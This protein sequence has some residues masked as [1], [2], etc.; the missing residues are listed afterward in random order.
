MKNKIWPVISLFLDVVLIAVFMLLVLFVVWIYRNPE[1]ELTRI[2]ETPVV[3]E[4]NIVHADEL[5]QVTQDAEGNGISYDAGAVEEVQSAEQLLHAQEDKSQKLYLRN[6]LSVPYA[7]VSKQI[8]E[9]L[10]EKVLSTGAGTVKPGQDLNKVGNFSVAAHNLRDWDAGTGF[11]HFQKFTDLVGQNMYVCDGEYVFTYR[12][13]ARESVPREDSMKYTDDD[14][15]NQMYQDAVLKYDIAPELVETKKIWNEDGTYRELEYPK[16][17]RYG[18]FFSTYTCEAYRNN[19]TGRY[20]SLKRI[21]VIGILIDKKELR[22]VDPAVQALFQEAVNTAVANGVDMTP[23]I[24]EEGENVQA[25]SISTVSSSNI[26]DGR[27]VQT[28]VVEKAPF[29]G[30]KYKDSF[31]RYIYRKLYDGKIN[32]PKRSAYILFGVFVVLGLCDFVLKWKLD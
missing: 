1:Y 30:A 7:A 8:F 4:S 27:E 28:T 13:I 15:V 3:S 9:G 16:T 14:Y 2:T 31:E 19:T 21:L 18:H 24:P 12:I 22:N 5:E 20:E 11:S 25:E 29:D 23:D 26:E 6:Y 17:F 32:Y 10:S